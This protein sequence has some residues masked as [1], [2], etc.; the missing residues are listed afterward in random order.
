LPPGF[1]VAARRYSPKEACAK[2]ITKA[3]GPE[4]KDRIYL[5]SKGIIHEEGFDNRSSTRVAES[6]AERPGLRHAHAELFHQS[7]GPWPEFFAAS[8]AQTSENSLV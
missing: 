5:S 3:L 6:F 2:K 8:R 4:R 1:S 7:R